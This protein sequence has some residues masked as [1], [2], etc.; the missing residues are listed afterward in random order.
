MSFARGMSELRR[1]WG[2]L[3]ELVHAPPPDEAVIRER[4][5]FVERNIGLWVKLALAPLIYWFVFNPGETPSSAPRE[6]LLHYLRTFTLLI[7]CCSIGAAI[8]LWGMDEVSTVVLERVVHVMAI[9][10]LA[11]LGS[12]TLYSGGY[13]SILY[14][15]FLGLILRNAAV[16]SRPSVQMLVNLT[17]VATYVLAGRLDRSFDLLERSV[18]ESYSPREVS[19][20]G[21]Y[22]PPS[23][24]I[25]SLVTRI[26]LLV[27]M[28]AVATSLRILFDRQRHREA[29]AR[30]FARKQ[31]QLE[32]AGRLAAEIAH[33]LKNPLGVINNAAYTLQKTVREGKTITQQIAIIREEVARSDRIITE[34]MGYAQ[35]AEGRVERLEIA[36]LI[37]EAV[38]LALPAGTDF[39]IR[40]ERT[41]GPALPVLLG[42]RNHFVEIFANLL[43]NAR[44]A[45]GGRGEIR[46]HVQSTP[47]YAVLVTVAD[48]G[49]GIPAESLG[50]IW[51]PYYTTKDRG[52]GLGL[53]I[54]R[55][56]AEIYGGRVR[57][58]SELGKGTCF[59][60]TLPARTVMRLRP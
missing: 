30:E 41:F 53:A 35:L 55:H 21:G 12:L 32:A 23:E 51:E 13:S 31:E 8:V 58:E 18:M 45:M 3:L 49:P 17:A 54:V 2:V 46:I 52:T 7:T 1:R 59:F 37:D 4:L 10:D 28:A 38:R 15:V 57:V 26:L 25:E 14:W 40:V 34:L 9:L 22:E 16:I 20:D 29:E 5:R 19:E 39:D 33:Q 11:F 42:Q 44:E 47:E 27:L 24:P 48:N 6:D 60:I 50:K 36:D 56:N 43:V